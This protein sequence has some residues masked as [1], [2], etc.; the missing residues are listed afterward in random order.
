[1]STTRYFEIIEKLNEAISF[2]AKIDSVTCDLKED[3]EEKILSESS[4][5]IQE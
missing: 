4:S 1:M 3:L 5:I 2:L